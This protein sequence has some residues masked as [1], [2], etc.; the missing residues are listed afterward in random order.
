MTNVVVKNCFEVEVPDTNLFHLNLSE[1]EFRDDR[2][3]LFIGI[4]SSG[5]RR[6]PNRFMSRLFKRKCLLFN[7]WA[8]CEF[9]QRRLNRFSDVID[10]DLSF[11]RVLNICPYTVEWKNKIFGEERNIFSFYPIDVRFSFLNSESEKSYDVVYHGGIHGIEHE[12][13]LDSFKNFDYAYCSLTSRI[14][15]LTKKYL[16][17]ATHTDLIFTDKLKVVERSKSSVCFNLC[18]IFPE[19]VPALEYNLARFKKENEAF[20]DLNSGVFPQFKVRMHEAALLKSVNLVYKD[21]WNVAERFYEPGKDFLYFRNAAE[22]SDL[23]A[24][25]KDEYYSSKV[26]KIVESAFSRV[27]SYSS[28]KFLAS[29]SSLIDG[30]V[31]D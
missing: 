21:E 13:M 10:F 5:L 4:N 18:H 6:F 31:D 19:H 25:V 30:S 14:N 24:Y 12:W 27:Q 20:K 17:L 28:Y 3:N 22:L 7:N 8:P 29:C 23:I 2:F 15:S 26:Q 9:S 16:P 11:D 1:I